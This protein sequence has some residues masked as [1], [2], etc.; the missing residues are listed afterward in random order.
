MDAAGVF[1]DMFNK[2]RVSNK[3]RSDRSALD[4]GE[5]VLSTTFNN[6]PCT[7]TT[8]QSQSKWISEIKKQQ[9]N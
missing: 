4:A 5:G 1:R 3:R 6:N 8:S 7:V 2:R 9:V